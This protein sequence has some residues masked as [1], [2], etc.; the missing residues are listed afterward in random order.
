MKKKVLFLAANPEGTTAGDL[1]K[2]HREIRAGI[3][4][5]EYRDSLELITAFA[6]RP[7]DLMQ[8]LLEHKPHIVHFTGHG[9]SAQEI[10]LEGNDGQPQA[11]SKEA[12]LALFRALKDNIQLVLLIACYSEPQAKAITQV[13]DCTIGMDDAIRVDAA[14]VF[15][16]S[17]YRALGFG[18][19]V[20]EAFELGKAALLLEGI[21]GETTPQLLLRDGVDPSQL[22]LVPSEDPVGLPTALGEP[23]DIV[24]PDGAWHTHHGSWAPDMK[25]IVYVHDADR[26]NIYELVEER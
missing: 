8:L 14:I 6:T 19:S 4:S 26:A 9:T 25:S 7:D 22:A 13:I 17:F 21:P 18:R 2:Q 20:R 11:V 10:I 5:A 16:A 1:D 23:L 12:L 3:R 15:S 24:R